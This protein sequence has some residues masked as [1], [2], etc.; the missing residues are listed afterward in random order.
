MPQNEIIGTAT[1]KTIID[2][3]K[4]MNDGSLILKPAFQINL[5]WNDKH[6]ENFLET[7]LLMYPFPEVY[8]ASGDIDTDLLEAKT[9]VV[10]GQQRL[11]TIYQYI[12]GSTDLVLSRIKKF[13]ELS[14]EEKEAFLYYTVVVREL[15]RTSMEIIK[16]IFKRINSIQYALNAME[17]NNALYEG[18]YINT[19]KRISSIGIFYVLNIYTDS[20]L[21]RMRDV[22]LVL[23]I[24]TTAEIGGYFS[25][26]KEVETFI[27][28][29]ENNYPRKDEMYESFRDVLVLIKKL[30]LPLDSI[31]F[32]K[33]CIFSLITELLII[34]F[35]NTCPLPDAKNLRKLL[36]NLELQI[37]K[38]KNEGLQ[39][40]YNSF[41][42]AIFQGTSNRRGRMIRG[43]LL[44]EEI[45][46]ISKN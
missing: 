10:D 37:L 24:M 46:E 40:K 43:K 23:V 25:G 8:F 26:D 19:A 11:S 2:L 29:Y 6:K 1:N 7:I 33:S 34:K 9:L 32:R 3:Y 17:I 12:S 20:E 27:K 22:E 44:R 41:Y 38:S 35:K 4:M 15:G 31:W 36:D 39:D 45:R 14:K 5:V 28:Q 21:S 42:S 18:E 16:E 30:A 13:A